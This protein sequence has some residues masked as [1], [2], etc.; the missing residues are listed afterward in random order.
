[1][2]HSR[3]V[4]LQNYIVTHIAT[5]DTDTHVG[6]SHTQL[7]SGHSDVSYW[8][9]S[10]PECNWNPDRRFWTVKAVGSI[11]RRGGKWIFCQVTG[12]PGDRRFG[13]GY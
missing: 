11:T 4:M 1:M 3:L 2:I 13:G 5:G 7:S 8:N 12:E 10:V 6:F 9:Q